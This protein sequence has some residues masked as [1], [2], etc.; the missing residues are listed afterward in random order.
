MI[1]YNALPL[2]LSLGSQFDVFGAPYV[3][4]HGEDLLC[5]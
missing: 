1:D 4:G 5:A 3:G 2:M